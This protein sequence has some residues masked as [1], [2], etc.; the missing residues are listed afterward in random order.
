MGESLIAL[1]YGEALFEAAR[2]LGK[3]AQILEEITC[4]A[5][6][7]ETEESLQKFLGNPGL[8]E[9]EKKEFTE[10]VLRGK[11]SDEMVNFIFVLIDKGRT[12]HLPRIARQ[13]QYLYDQYLGVTE[14]TIYSAQPITEEQ[15]A[16]AEAAMSDLLQKQVTLKNEVEPQL[17]GGVKIQADGR[18]LDRSLKGELE[19]MMASL[20]L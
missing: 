19:R 15:M 2:E 1:T 9:E 12:W 4:L 17:I 3:E 5:H 6:I 8:Q 11:V 16:E 13:Y 7:M 10:A 18:L 20:K 14:G